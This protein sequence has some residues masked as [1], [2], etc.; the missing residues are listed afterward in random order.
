LLDRVALQL[1]SER[2]YVRM[3]A[4]KVEQQRVGVELDVKSCG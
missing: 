3:A 4:Q 2:R 1:R